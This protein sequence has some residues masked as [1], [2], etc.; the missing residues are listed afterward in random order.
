MQCGASPMAWNLNTT[1]LQV[2]SPT[3]ALREGLEPGT[4]SSQAPHSKHYA[5][6]PQIWLLAVGDNDR[7]YY[8]HLS[9][10]WFKIAKGCSISDGSLHVL[11][12]GTAITDFSQKKRML[13]LK[14]TQTDKHYLTGVQFSYLPEKRSIQIPHKA[15]ISS[16]QQ[17]TVKPLL[18][19][20]PRG[21]SKY[22]LNR[23]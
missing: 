14:Q 5:I 20:H 9:L 23:G 3:S 15:A 22:S 2:T 4:S 8:N 21:M 6:P 13:H 10:K 7:L 16:Q 19:D 11:S 17:A 18:S 12:D 1:G